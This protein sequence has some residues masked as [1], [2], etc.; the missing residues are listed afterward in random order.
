MRYKAGKYSIPRTFSKRSEAGELLGI[1]L[2]DHVIIGDAGR[3][4][5]LKEKGF[6]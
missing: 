4:T 2:L 5:S 6:L 3:W 1:A